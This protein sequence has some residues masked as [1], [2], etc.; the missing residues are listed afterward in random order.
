MIDCI[1]TIDY[2]IY[3]NGEGS[4]KDLVLDPAQR[5]MVM[6]EEW[7]VPFVAFVEAAEFE[8]IE[9]RGS[10]SAISDVQNQIREFHRRG[11]EVG[12]HLHPQWYNATY[13]NGRWSLDYREYNLCT[14]PRERITDV[15]QRSIDYLS[16][17]TGDPT[18]VPLSFRARD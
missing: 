15:V 11:F 12:L 9:E 2:E 16:Y 5:L 1:F 8:R 10:D 18:F 13:Q 14:L 3:G 7:N 6:F 17:A 4:L